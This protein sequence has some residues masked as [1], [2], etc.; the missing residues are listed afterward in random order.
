MYTSL[1]RSGCA[2]PSFDVGDQLE[3]QSCEG[4]HLNLA[5]RTEFPTS[6]KSSHSRCHRL[7]RR[8][9]LWTLWFR[10]L[11]PIRWR[12]SLILNFDYQRC[13][14]LTGTIP[15]SGSGTVSSSSDIT[16]W[17][18]GSLR[19]GISCIESPGGET[20]RSED[21]SDSDCCWTRRWTAEKIDFK[22]SFTRL[23][24]DLPW[25]QWVAFSTSKDSWFD[26]SNPNSSFSFQYA[27][28]RPWIHMGFWTSKRVWA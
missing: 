20:D 22:L 11:N 27:N 25:V 3:Q 23:M 2:Y 9:S 16:S 4:T 18:F 24:K 12:W 6:Q 8:S 14:S 1:T 10:L 7:L 26:S 28:N 19:Y 21:D 15:Q 5:R 13:G 17:T